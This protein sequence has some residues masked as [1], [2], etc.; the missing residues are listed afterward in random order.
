MWLII[1]PHCYA[2]HK[3]WPIAVN[4]QWSVMDMSYSKKAIV[5]MFGLW[6]RVGHRNHVLGGGP[7]PPKGRGNFGVSPSQLCS[8]GIPSTS[9]S[10]SLYGSSNVAFHCQ[11]CSNLLFL[12][13]RSIVLVCWTKI[14]SHCSQLSATMSNLFP[15]H[16]NGAN[17]FT[18]F[19][20]IRM[21]DLAG[22][23]IPSMPVSPAMEKQQVGELFWAVE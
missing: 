14:N 6:T 1:K 12:C 13:S 19:C 8:K 18:S 3:T 5:M 4:V 2:K 17:L 21:T 23:Q 9:Q 10:Y 11:N 7:D 20:E 16:T 22:W 15:K